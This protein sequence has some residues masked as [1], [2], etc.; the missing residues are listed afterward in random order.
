MQFQPNNKK[1]G[2][3]TIV[4]LSVWFYQKL[5]GRKLFDQKLFD[6]KLFDQKLFD[7]KLFDPKLFDPKLFDPK[8]FDQKYSSSLTRTHG[9]PYQTSLIMCLTL[10]M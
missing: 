10:E 2:I 6:Q 7:P 1:K 3:R 9:L 8:L 4:I 5:F